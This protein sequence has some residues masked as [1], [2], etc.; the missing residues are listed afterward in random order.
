M[1]G[2]GSV[3]ERL[4]R[5]IN[6][7]PGCGVKNTIRDKKTDRKIGFRAVLRMDYG[8]QEQMVATGFSYLPDRPETI[9]VMAKIAKIG[10]AEDRQILVYFDDRPFHGSLIFH[11]R[12]F[13]DHG[14]SEAKQDERK[15]RGEQWLNLDRDWACTLREYADGKAEPR[16]EPTKQERIERDGGWFDV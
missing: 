2:D 12:S 1:P 6:E 8:E 7:K 9:G 14:I 16:V 15:Q 13:L 3:L 10:A 11:P 5:M 4:F